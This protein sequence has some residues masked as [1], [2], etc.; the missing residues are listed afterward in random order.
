MNLKRQNQFFAFIAGLLLTGCS[1]QGTSSGGVGNNI[2][3]NANMQIIIF[4]DGEQAMQK[5]FQD[6][7]YVKP[8]QGVPKTN[9]KWPREFLLMCEFSGSFPNSA[10]FP[11]YEAGVD[12][13]SPPLNCFE[14]LPTVTPLPTP[15]ESVP[16]LETAKRNDAVTSYDRMFGFLDV[17]YKRLNNVQYKISLGTN[18]KIKTDDTGKYLYIPT[19]VT[20]DL[21][22]YTPLNFDENPLI[23]GTSFSSGDRSFIFGLF[24]HPPVGNGRS[25]PLKF[26]EETGIPAASFDL[27]DP[28]NGEITQRYSYGARASFPSF[29]SEFP[30]GEVT[31][32]L[33]SFFVKDKFYYINQTD[34]NA[35]SQ[36][37]G[38]DLEPLADSSGRVRIAMP[39][40]YYTTSFKPRTQLRAG[41]STHDTI[42]TAMVPAELP[43]FTVNELSATVSYETSY[44]NLLEQVENGSALRPLPD[45]FTPIP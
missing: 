22:G 10:S 43:N 25:I 30:G 23:V 3:S 31:R 33:C 5:V 19:P 21:T 28:V 42:S 14:H 45:A 27:T 4:S 34:L 6:P 40:V 26:D 35:F 8:C 24:A 39:T 9:L 38:V 41:T 7:E 44:A 13:P 17:L 2:N 11:N 29:D 12:S 18:F 32:Y 16:L 36:V 15:Y 37:F 1:V 20:R